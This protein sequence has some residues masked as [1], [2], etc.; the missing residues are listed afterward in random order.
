MSATTL[1]AP[2]RAAFARTADR[3][4]WARPA[5]AVLLLG[6]AALYLVNLSANG[7][8]NSFYAGA[9]QAGTISWKALLFGA[10]DAGSGI[11]VDKPPASIWLMAL[12][13]RVFGFS[14]WSMLVPQA[15]LGVASVALLYGAVRRVA[16]YAAGL[17]AG[18]I[19]ALT[20]V[21]VLMF[22]FNN[23]DALLVLLMV[24]GAYA[25]TRAV[26]RGSLWWLVLAGT[27]LGFGFLTK[28]L[29]AFLVLPAFALVYLVAAPVSLRRRI[30]HLLA[31]GAALV[32]SAGWYV[33]LVELWPAGSR[34]YIGGSTDNSLLQLALG[35]NGLSRLTGGSGGGPGGGGMPGGAREV[36]TGGGSGAPVREVF[37]G[38]GPGG[39]GNAMFG[40]ATG[41]LRM[42]SDTFGT[43]IS[44]LLPA[45]LLA[46]VAGLWLTR[47]ARRTDRTR[48][49]LVLWGG[50]L[51]VTMAVFSF[52]S[53]IIHPY[54]SVALAPAIA[55]VVAIGGHTLWEQRERTGG[56]VGLAVLV[57]VTGVWAY[58]LLGR[59]PSWQPWLR[60][61]VLVTAAAGVVWLLV[62]GRW[63]RRVALVAVP[64]LA[65]AGLGAP[66]AYSAQTAATAHTGSIPTAGPG[67]SGA[68]GRFGGPG[69]GGRGRTG[70]GS[71]FGT[72]PGG[73]GNPNAAGNANGG[74]GSGGKGG[75][76]GATGGR[77]GTG[78]P[79]TAGIPGS[80]SGSQDNSGQGNSGQGNSARGNSG[81][82]GQGRPG[83][84]S[85]SQGTGSGQNGRSG[86]GGVPGGGMGGGS[87]NSAV[88]T[89]L[90]NA[91]GYRWAAAT[92]GTQQAAE[93]ELAAD[94]ASVL[95]IGGFSGSDAYPTR[96]QFQRYVAAGEVRYFVAG[97]MGGGPGG[98][99]SIESWVAAHFTKKTVGG[100]TVYDLSRP[101]S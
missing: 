68:G 30:G 91:H 41:P 83:A 51:L 93:L 58:Q 2:V 86:S 40:G 56:R 31:A 28:M 59:A 34:P 25:V 9:V 53:G 65:F 52:M 82:P 95:G 88:A 10:V 80:G 62:P 73:S 17:G 55:A 3:P 63:V 47:A 6:T 19:L 100:V 5:L 97:G 38:G 54:Y 43:Q 50:W 27:A 23:P 32:V 79:P 42:F 92:N 48:A 20:P 7:Y 69:M 70:S 60:Y 81:V 94:G 24:A 44:W 74:N 8:A 89:L 29:Q 71:G 49:A 37:T 15:L 78:Q 66:A 1:T 22:R 26:E 90:K 46:L 96:A 75:P 45:A 39:G 35:Y 85:D 84:G 77:S 98:T 101:T 99:S 18:A 87:A 4:G 14:S 33:A 64:V 21:A 12:S 67:G 76:G 72:P 57:A 13:G 11:T 36:F 61:A 16:G